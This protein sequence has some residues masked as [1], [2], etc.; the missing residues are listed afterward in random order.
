MRDNQVLKLKASSE[1]QEPA[2]IPVSN[3][4]LKES[5]KEASSHN[6]VKYTYNVLVGAN[7]RLALLHR[8]KP[9]GQSEG[10]GQTNLPSPCWM[11]RGG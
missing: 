5:N 3:K 7:N 4:C 9:G 2:C 6:F 10:T 8:L 11:K 1:H